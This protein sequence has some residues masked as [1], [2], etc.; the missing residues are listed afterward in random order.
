MYRQAHQLQ[1][2]LARERLLRQQLQQQLEP[3]QQQ[4][5]DLLRQ[6]A[7]PVVLEDD[8]Q[9]EFATVGQA[10]GVSLPDCRVLLGVL[11]PDCPGRPSRVRRVATLGRR[12]QEAGETAG[13]LLAVMDEFTRP[14]VKDLAADEMYVKAPVLMTVEPESLCW[15]TGQLSDD[16][17]G[18]SWSKVFV[19]FDQLEQVDRG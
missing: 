1:E 2:A 18:A 6:R 7:H 15:L 17:S 14:P 13:P 4:V 5:A 10:R 9:A 12:T 11:L 16:V 8:N 19:S 3:L